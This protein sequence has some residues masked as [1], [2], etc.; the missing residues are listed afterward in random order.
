MKKQIIMILAVCLMAACGG[1]KGGTALPNIDDVE[2]GTGTSL[3]I[4]SSTTTKS[5][6]NSVVTKITSILNNSI[7]ST[8]NANSAAATAQ[9]CNTGS[10]SEA[11][12][13]VEVK[14]TSG[15]ANVSGN[16]SASRNSSDGGNQRVIL[17]GAFA[18]YQYT[19]SSAGGT[20]SLSG[21]SKYVANVDID[22]G[23]QALCDA[24]TSGSSSSSSTYQATL[25]ETVSGAVS[26]SGAYGAAMVYS[27]VSTTTVSGTSSSNPSSNMTITGEAKVKAGGETVSCT[28]SGSGSTASL[29]ITCN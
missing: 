28:I 29:N 3:N 24:S 16:A 2:E 8:L 12:G 18:A 27:V 17:E 20:L 26:I 15:T 10:Y 4:S 7:D 19:S 25:S 5:A 9:V 22:S 13:P 21:T 14:G 6:V 11:L 1:T 23:V